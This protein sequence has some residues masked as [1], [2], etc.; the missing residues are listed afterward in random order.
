MSHKNVGRLGTLEYNS[1]RWRAIRFFKQLPL[2]YVMS[3]YV[4]FIVSRKK[5]ILLYSPLNSY[6][7]V[8]LIVDLKQ[9]LLLLLLLM[10]LIF[11]C[12]FVF[13]MRVHFC[14]MSRVLRH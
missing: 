9:I 1:F 3:L 13:L 12:K 5:C 7:Y 2:F 10:H 8:H 11:I 4:L 6:L 14:R